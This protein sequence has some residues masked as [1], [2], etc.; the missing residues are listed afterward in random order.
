[1]REAAMASRVT[2]ACVTVLVIL[3]AATAARARQNPYRLKNPDQK[4]LCL[5]CHTDFE[6]TLGKRSVHTP[7]RSG[8]CSDCHDP[9]VSSHGKLLAGEAG[10]ICVS[11]HDGVVPA[12]AKSTHKVV[13]DGACGKCHDPHASDTPANLLASGSDLC[14]GCHKELGAAVTTARFKHAPVQ[15]GCL[16]CHDPHGSDKSV[17]LLK[18]AVPALC[19]GCHKTDTPAF[20]ERHMKYPVGKASCTSCHDPH[21]SNQAALLLNTVHP[22]VANRA[23]NQ[24][25]EAADSATPFAT[26]RTSY[27]LCKGCHND[28]LTAALSKSR[29]HWPA[30][31]KRGCINCHNPHASRYA[32]LLKTDTARLCSSCHAD[33]A[34]RT[35]AVAEKHA[36]VQE[37]ACTTCHSPHAANGVY[38]VDQP[39]LLELC[40][41]CH[42]YKDHSAHPLGEAAV[43]PRNKNLR[44]DCLSCHRGH[45]TENK[46]MLRAADNLTLCTQCHK[47]YGR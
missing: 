6:R 15:K 46:H 16:T 30:V 24:C 22:P 35:A 10:Q 42:D 1:M 37:G 9:H 19:V 4:A 27:E 12:A 17:S 23:C 11:C 36:P 25:H 40:G 43:D 26:K 31:D 32:G 29:V 39:S 18:T 2:I 33:T 8:E 28:M 5:P 21:G 13:A 34:R 14:L 7:V 44:V 3:G 47:Q 41:T 20:V 38:L 45:G